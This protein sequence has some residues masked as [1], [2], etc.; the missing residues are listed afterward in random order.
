MG[1]YH[2]CVVPHIINLAMNQRRLLPYRERVLAG[3]NGRVLEIGVGAGANFPLYTRPVT[4]V[5]GL[6]PH[7]QLLNMA[8]TQ[9]HR[10]FPMIV[11]GSAE[12]IPLASNAVDTVVMTWTLCSIRGANTA[13]EEIWRV[14]KPGGQ[15]LFVEHGLSTEE[16]VR[17][18][19][20]RLTPCWRRIAG[21]CHLDRPVGELVRNAG[22]EI[23]QLTTAY[24]PGPKP[25]TFIYEGIARRP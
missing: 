9:P 12:S 25:M 3:A 13:L 14:L 6:D 16:G 23:S 19:Q 11:E 1:W 21:G 24:M 20:R 8:V 18:W 15:L 5:I 22:F 17:R 4:E 2:R 10:V 7:R